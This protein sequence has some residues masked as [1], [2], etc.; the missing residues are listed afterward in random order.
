MKELERIL[1]EVARTETA[2][3]GEED[4][5]RFCRELGAAF[6][7]NAAQ[8]V[9]SAVKARLEKLREGFDAAHNELLRKMSAGEGE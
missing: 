4:L 2:V 6:G 3:A 8:G 9:T 1:A 7:A 5:S